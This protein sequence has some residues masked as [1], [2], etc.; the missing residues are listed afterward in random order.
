[1]SLYFAIPFLPGGNLEWIIVVMAALMIFG[2]RLPEVA[3]RAVAHVMRIRRA[4]SKMWRDTGLEDELRRVRRD[5]E[6]SIPKDA[7]FSVKPK[8]PAKPAG[9]INDARVAAE[10]AR[11]AAARSARSSG[12]SADSDDASTDPD[13]H[14]SG[15]FRLEAAPGIVAEGDSL[16]DEDRGHVPEFDRQEPAGYTMP[17]ADEVPPAQEA[18]EAQAPESNP[19]PDP[20]PDLGGTHF[21]AGIK[22]RPDAS[23]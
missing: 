9:E 21:G 15:G 17:E 10:K 14:R 18:A 12:D 3:L 16:A 6:L 23:S 20:E 11:E 7:D 22:P 13:A 1:M 2:S 8:A 19:E 5:I 4:I